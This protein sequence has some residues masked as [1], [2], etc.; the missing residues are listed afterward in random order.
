M[1]KIFKY[2]EEV[3]TSYPPFKSK[4]IRDLIMQFCCERVFFSNIDS[5]FC[6]LREDIEA[7]I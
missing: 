3:L 7:A 6:K 5:F 4:D 1:N 2:E